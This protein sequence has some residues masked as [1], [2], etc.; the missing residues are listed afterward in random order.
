MAEA[1]L[2]NQAEII[3]GIDDLLI[4][5]H[6]AMKPR[7][8]YRIG[9]EAEKFGV[10]TTTGDPLPYEGARSV[11]TV[12]EAL[13]ER[14]GWKMD[15]ES[16]TG[17]IIALER[18]GASVTLEPG[19]QLELSGAAFDNVHQIC[20]EMSGHLAELRDIS[21]E[22]NLSWLGIGFHP[23]ARQDE[24]PWVPKSR[25][26]IMRRYLPTVGT[27]GLDMMRRTATVQAN[28]DYSSEEGAMRAL[29]VSLRL[30]PVVTAMFA[31]SPF[32][33]GALWGGKSRRALTWLDVD[34]AR[35]GLLENVLERGKR[36]VDYVEWALDAPMFLIKRGD[37]VLENTGQSFRSFLKHGFRGHHATSTDWQTHLNTLFPE[38]RLKRTIE[39]RGADSQSA[40]LT[41]ALPALWTGILYDDRALDEAEALTE[42][43]TFAELEALRPAITQQA[44][45]ATFRGERLAALAERVLVIAEGGLAR[46]ARMRN[47]KDERVHLAR[48]GSL[49]EKGQCPAD[50][51][52]EGLGEG[53]DLRRE[54]LVRS[55]I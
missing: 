51:L 44:L 34:P 50:A 3:R 17:P 41:C 21:G 4:P 5:F 36:F 53:S 52:V 16:A 47:G 40:A 29:R 26:G 13:V 25:Y 55:R 32:V 48:L 2:S 10:D 35:Q 28:F 20:L 12:L 23:L 8:R 18:A 24:L 6:A 30:S 45:E 19:G 33:E 22:L 15:R 54:I 46:R 38:V 37:V 7:D 1:S 9:A 31:N 39:V 43:F 11:L 27:G 49:V 14:H 42:S